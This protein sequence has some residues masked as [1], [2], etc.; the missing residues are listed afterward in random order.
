[1]LAACSVSVR[2]AGVC[3]SIAARGRN[4]R[5]RL[6]RCSTLAL[7]ALEPECLTSHSSGGADGTDGSVWSE[8]LTSHWSGGTDLLQNT[9]VYI[10][11]PNAGLPGQQRQPDVG[12]DVTV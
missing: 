10:L 9:K 1:M 11:L 5:R 2:R 7:T 4:C 3:E 6:T 12:D 8:C